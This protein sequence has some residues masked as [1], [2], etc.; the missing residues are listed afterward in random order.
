[1][2]NIF[3]SKRKKE[4]KSAK[5]QNSNKI[6]NKLNKS[7]LYILLYQFVKYLKFFYKR[8]IHHDSFCKPLKI[9]Y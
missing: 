1:M 6:F 4:A 2:E 5:K 7:L 8:K 3:L 9:T